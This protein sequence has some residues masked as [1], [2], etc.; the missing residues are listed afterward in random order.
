MLYSNKTAG[1][2]R[3]MFKG[4]LYLNKQIFCR[5]FSLH[6]QKLPWRFAIQ[7]FGHEI[8]K[9]H[10]YLKISPRYGLIYTYGDLSSSENLGLAHFFLAVHNDL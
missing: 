1:R 9:T 3:K 6:H 4:E 10:I 7:I 8:T 2:T 5:G